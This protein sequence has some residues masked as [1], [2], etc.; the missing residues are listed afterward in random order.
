MNLEEDDEIQVFLRDKEGSVEKMG[1]VNIPATNN[2]MV[3][4]NP[5]KS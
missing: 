5:A 3:N 1:D 2:E 4:I